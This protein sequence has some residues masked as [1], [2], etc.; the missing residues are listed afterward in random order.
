M[1]DAA[2]T[3]S[4]ARVWKPIPVALLCAGVEEKHWR[5]VLPML[6]S[7]HWHHWNV[8]SDL[9]KDPH[10]GG[11]GHNENGTHP[12]TIRQVFAQDNFAA[13]IQNMGHWCVNRFLEDGPNGT[14]LVVSCKRGE[15]RSDVCVRKLQETLNSILSPSGHRLFNCTI[16][17][18]NEAYGW[19]GVQ[20]MLDEAWRWRENPWTLIPSTAEKPK[21]HRYG[22][23]EVLSSERAHHN[24]EQLYKYEHSPLLRESDSAIHKNVPDDFGLLEAAHRSLAGPLEPMIEETWESVTKEANSDII[25]I[26]GRAYAP[27][28]QP[29]IDDRAPRPPWASLDF[30]VDKWWD[31]L[32][33]FNIDTTAQ[34]N[35]FFLAQMSDAG[36]YEA[37]DLL[38]KLQ[39]KGYK[40]ELQDANRWLHS[41]CSKARA[42]LS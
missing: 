16:F 42:R 13:L 4:T 34:R 10:G 30:D 35:L 22:W 6:D 23:L 15:H 26:D 8:S 28:V 5:E 24:F 20:V 9:P 12:V 14:G 37:L 18:L 33:E 40:N 32:Q 21:S 39:H 38:V 1:T 17:P 25:W 19:A 3:D 11:I 36:K 2:M 7:E 29:E 27:L 41:S 31:L